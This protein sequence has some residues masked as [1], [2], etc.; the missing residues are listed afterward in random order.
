MKFYI[1]THK[2]TYAVT[3]VY[4]CDRTGYHKHEQKNIAIELKTGMKE[5]CNHKIAEKMVKNIYKDA[6]IISVVY[7]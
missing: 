2:E 6:K 1:P 5:K 3:F 4:K 7:V